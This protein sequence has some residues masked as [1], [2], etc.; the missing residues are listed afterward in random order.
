MLTKF[1]KQKLPRLFAVHDLNRDG[2]I[3]RA[4]FEEYTRRIAST[5]GWGPESPEYEELLT[6]FLT[7]WNGLEQSARA[8]GASEV[9]LTEWFEYWDRILGTPGMYEQIAEPIGRMVFTILDQN[10][11][12]SITAAEYTAAFS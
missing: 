4:D 8:L 5:R 9:T 3:N 10:G 12:G 11:D 7:F 1:Q 2:V 6:R